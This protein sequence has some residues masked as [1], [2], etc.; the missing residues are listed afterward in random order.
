ML[1]PGA[2][3]RF[4]YRTVAALRDIAYAEPAGDVAEIKKRFW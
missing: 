4:K 2:A 1:R 3:I